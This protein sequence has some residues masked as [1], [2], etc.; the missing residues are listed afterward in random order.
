PRDALPRRRR[1]P[2]HVQGLRR[3]LRR[4]GRHRGARAGGTDARG[5]RAPRHRPEPDR[6][7][8]PRARRDRPR[9]G[10]TP[11][12]A[13][14][15]GRRRAV[16]PAHRRRGTGR[17]PAVGTLCPARRGTDAAL[18]RAGPSGT[19]VPRLAVPAHRGTRRSAP[20]IDHRLVP[21]PG[22]V[23]ETF[24]LGSGP[25][26]LLMHPFNIGAGIFAG[27]FRALADRYRLIVVHH[28]GVG[29][30]TAAG[31]LTL[32]GIVA[33][34]RRVLAELGAR[35]PF[36]VAGTSFGG[37]LALNFALAHPADPA[38]PTL[39]RGSHRD[40]NRHGEVNRLDRV[41]A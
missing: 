16:R 39:L 20:G 25:V 5:R 19:V 21:A 32:D 2:Q 13:T 10:A 4:P 17:R 22:G 37:I 27:Q 38:T 23:V 28:P 29:G 7:P 12:P 11:R 9:R 1:H 40:A 26:L 15:G 31:D 8:Y 36:H 6:P 41:I 14:H 18:R 3:G 33:Q 35:P 30:T 34:H 24:A